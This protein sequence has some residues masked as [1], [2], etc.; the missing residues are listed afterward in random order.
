MAFEGLQVYYLYLFA[1]FIICYHCL[2][3]NKVVYI[4]RQTN[5]GIPEN[6]YLMLSLRRG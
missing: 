5:R 4:C 3:M 6:A 2:M 1:Y